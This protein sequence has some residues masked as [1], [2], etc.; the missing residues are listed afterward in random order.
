VKVSIIIAVYKDTQALELILEALENQTYQNFEVIIS[1]DDNSNEV[2]NVLKDWSKK[3]NIKHFSQEDQ[4][5][6]KTV[7]LNKVLSKIKTDYIIF[8]DGDVLP[9]SN[10][11]ET[12]VILSE[13]KVVLCGRRVNLGNKVSSD[14]RKKNISL[15]KIEKSYFKLF[16][17]LNSDNIRHYE[18]GIRLKPLSLIYKYL[19]G[20]D[21]NIHI[22]GTNFSCFLEDI[23]KINGFNEDIIGSSKDDVDL[24]WRFI[25]SGCTL[26]SC[27]FSANLLHLDHSR[28]NRK[29]NDEIA[30]EQMTIDKNNN[31]YICSN[32]I[33]K[34]LF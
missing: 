20:K 15:M 24:E 5:I 25:A 26:K 7:L 27:K 12:H 6:R 8:I 1:E 14:L 30:K 28:I 21:K 9:Y 13:K 31:N 3:L 17:Y 22:L 23:K 2:K 11:I 33:K 10:F 18:Q 16:R 29:E 34:D 19:R 4:G 32:G